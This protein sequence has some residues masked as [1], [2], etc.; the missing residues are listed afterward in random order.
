MVTD[1]ARQTGAPNAP[2]SGPARRRKMRF[3]VGGII[4]VLVVIG[5]M[6]VGMQ[7]ATTYYFTA[8][9]VKAKGSTLYGETIRMSG[10]A[11]E[12]TVE[13]DSKNLTM[14][15]IVTDDVAQVPVAFKGIVPDTFKPGADVVLEGK[16]SE[17]GVFQATS[18]L[19]K[20]PSK[21]VPSI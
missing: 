16:Y 19:T 6:I 9:E 21:Y 3:I 8:S 20:C 10:R 13:A 1:T 2:P 5:L 11:L 14:K 17:E 15:F 18:L 12:G 4:I 7:G